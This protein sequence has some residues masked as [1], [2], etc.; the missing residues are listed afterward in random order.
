MNAILKEL[1]FSADDRVVV[2]HADDVGMC[3]ASVPAWLDLVDAGLLSSATAMPACPWFP[4]VAAACRASPGLDLGV[5]LAITSE[6]DSYRWGPLTT[7]DEAGGLVDPSGSFWPTLTSCREHARPDAVAGEIAAQIRRARATGIDLTHVDTHMHALYCRQFLG[8]YVGS[9]LG[10]GLLPILTCRGGELYPRPP[11]EDRPTIGAWVAS[12]AARGV[13]VFDHFT[14][15]NLA[16]EH[17]A[18]TVAK[19][20]FDALEPGLTYLALHPARDTPELRAMS[21]RWPHRANEYRTFLDPSLRRHVVDRGI[22]VIGCRPIRDVMR[23]A[24]ADGR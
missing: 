16:D 17:Q 1:G 5:H 23:R 8:P 13:P 2:V 7:R 4:L 3:Q 19:A 14:M 20:A 6:W 24:L 12:W 22:Q 18:L 21:D 10:A 9:A 15:L 11:A